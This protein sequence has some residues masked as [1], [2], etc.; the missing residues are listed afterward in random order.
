[1]PTT[2]AEPSAPLIETARL[3]Q[4]APRRA[5]APEIERLAGDWEVARFTAMI[6]HPYPPGAALAWLDELAG[7]PPGREPVWAI[8]RRDDGAFIGVIG[9][10]RPADDTAEVGFWIGRPF[11]GHGYATEALRAALAHAF[12]VMGLSVVQATVNAENAASIRVQ[13][14]AGFSYVGVEVRPQPARGD[15]G[16][17]EVRELRRADWRG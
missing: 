14:K 5:D 10:K 8:A 15:P 7:A 16:P 3:S 6:P 9:L 11:W 4:R 1:M 12:E 13:E 17:V 2:A